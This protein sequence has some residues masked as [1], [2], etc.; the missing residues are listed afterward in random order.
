[1]ITVKR[2]ARNLDVDVLQIVLPCAVH[3]DALEQFVSPV[4]VHNGGL[5]RCL[6]PQRCR[7]PKTR[8]RRSRRFCAIPIFPHSLQATAAIPLFDRRMGWEEDGVEAPRV[9]T[10]G[11]RV[12]S[13]MRRPSGARPSG[14]QLPSGRRLRERFAQLWFLKRHAEVPVRI[15]YRVQQAGPC[16]VFQIE[17]VEELISA[18]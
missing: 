13:G 16:R 5:G 2:V 15:Y 7:S 10:S 8:K 11:M 3:G 18:C 12:P 6:C 1:M 14:T 17:R 9:Q 4:N